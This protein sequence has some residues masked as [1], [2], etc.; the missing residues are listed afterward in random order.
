MPIVS[1]AFFAAMIT[2]TFAAISARSTSIALP[3]T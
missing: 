1:A 2:H 3:K